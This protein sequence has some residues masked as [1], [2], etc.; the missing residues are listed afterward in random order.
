M[1]SIHLAETTSKIKLKSL[2]QKYQSIM[3][4]ATTKIRNVQAKLTLKENAKAIFCKARSVP[5]RLRPLVEEELQRLESEGILVKVDSS[6]WATPIVPVLKKN[7]QIRICGDF[8]VTLNSQLI[9]D[10]HP[11]PTADE[12]FASMAGGVIFSKIDL[13]QA[14]LQMEV[15]PE[16]RHLLTLNTHKGLYR[17]TRLM[18]GI[19]SAPAIW[20]RTIE[21][22]LGD[23]PGVAVFLDDIRIAGTSME[24]HVRTLE[25]VLIRLQKYNIR[26]NPEKSEF[27]EK[28]ISYCGYIIDKDGLHKAS[29]K[30]EAIEKMRKPRN[31]TEVRSFLG[32]INYY[33]RFI[34]N[35]SSI[36]HPLNNLLR[37]N[38]QFHW[39]KDCEKSFLAAKEAFTSPKCLVHF[40]PTLPIILATDAS[41]YGVG[42]VLSH[43]YPDGTER[44]IQY[45]SQTL[46][47]TQKSY[48]Q[49][50]KEAYA[51]IFGIKKFYQYLQ[52][53]HFTLVTDHRPLTQIFAPNKSLP[54]YSAMR[55]QHYALFLQGF[56]YTI[57]YRKSELHAN[58]DCLSR[59]PIKESANNDVIDAFQLSTI[60]T[61]P[62]TFTELAAATGKD[63]TLAKLLKILISGKS[64][65]KYNFSNVNVNEFTLQNGVILRGHKVVIP[66]TLQKKILQELHI[67]HFGVVKMKSIARGYVWWPNID[68]DIEVLA[69]NCQ[70]CNSFRNNPVKIEPHVWE[71]PTTAFSRVHADFAG[72]F[73]GCYFFIL[74]DAYTKWPEVHTVQDISAKTTIELCRRIFA[75]FGLPTQFVSDNG[76]TFT[77]N[78]FSQF[79]K[80]N[81]IT[82]KFTAPYNPSTNGLAERFVQT[83]KNSLRR[84]RT[85][86][87]NV[88]VALQQILLQY[89][90]A[91]HSTTGKSPA[92]LM[93]ARKLRTRLDLLFPTVDERYANTEAPIS[94]KEGERVSCRNYIGTDKWMFGKVVERIGKLH[95]TVRIDDGRIWKRHVNQMRKIGDKT[96]PKSDHVIFDSSD[97]DYD[98]VGGTPPTGEVI[99]REPVV[100]TP[101][102]LQAVPQ[103]S[104]VAEIPREVPPERMPITITPERPVTERPRRQRKLPTRLKD[105]DV[106]LE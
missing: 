54:I 62:I 35:L 52:G 48:S 50:D 70:N 4:P 9:V 23:I 76:K 8:S 75:T 38:I 83:I 51:I 32:M 19:A 37:K 21:N 82:Q 5:F 103:E 33:G 90:N 84:M 36:L 81:G 53:G 106:R 72:P 69:K 45:A 44:V 12:L 94:F 16:D 65:P 89:R 87:A 58:A 40:D 99:R 28:Q 91:T 17:C 96:P 26:I 55:M 64:P 98:T 13:L 101:H 56:R 67:G 41:P 25:T 46:S 43:L 74:V 6:E 60:E 92:E 18:Y 10:D 61:L 47:D 104:P 42:A 31:T 22:I 102:P 79:L 59:L 100:G 71:P 77:S 66:Q 97:T 15:R 24:D 73:L 7:G 34:P 11:L 14:Y 3:S 57:K 105:F 63:T 80:K 29:D 68:N 49:I 30:I 93:F 95:Y 86:Q 1:E 39:T 20:Q 78:E 85:D 2:L 88:Q 27:F